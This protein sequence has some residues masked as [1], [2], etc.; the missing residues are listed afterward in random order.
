MFLLKKKKTSIK[1]KTIPNSRRMKPKYQLITMT[2]KKEI[3]IKLE[4]LKLHRHKT[5]R[6]KTR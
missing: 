5:K 2:R 1:L 3:I 6:L 4:N